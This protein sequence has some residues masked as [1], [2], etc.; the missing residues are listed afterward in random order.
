MKQLWRAIAALMLAASFSCAHA[1]DTAKL[2]QTLEKNLPNVKIGAI[3]KLPYTA[4]YQVVGNGINVFYTDA[5][6]NVAFFGKMVDLKNKVN[7]TDEESQKLRTVDFASLPFKD[8]F[9]RVKGNGKRKLA[10]FSDPDCP[11]C[12]R[13]ERE[14]ENVDNV[15]IYTF[16]YPLNIHPDS[17]RKAGQIW[18]AKDSA[19]AWDDWMLKQKPLP[20]GEAKCKTPIKAIAALA[21]KLWITGTPGLIFSNG[22]LVPGV[23]QQNQLKVL[24]DEAAGK[25]VASG[26]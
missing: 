3:K 26:D 12:K 21:K 7:L 19:K 20:S 13:L 16:L 1:D 8:A 10:I 9:V 2:K 14:L 18:C 5:S 25:K 6:G 4:L 11:F 23:P 24:L 17:H 22:K 15:T